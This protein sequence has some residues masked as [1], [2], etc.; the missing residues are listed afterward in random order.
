[1]TYLDIP[2]LSD[3]ELQKVIAKANVLLAQ[4]R[5]NSC[6]LVLAPFKGNDK[7]GNRRRRLDYAL[8]RQLLNEA[9]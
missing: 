9:S 8:A 1:M 6:D 2:E 5:E 4:L 3:E 7:L